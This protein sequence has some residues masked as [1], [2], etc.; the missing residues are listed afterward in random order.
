[1]PAELQKVIDT[2]LK[3]FPVANAF[4]DDILVVLKGIEIEHIALV[5]KILRKLNVSK[6]ALKLRKSEFAKNECE[7]LDFRI[8]KDGVTPLV[9]KNQV[10]EDLK[11]PKSRKQLKLLMGSLHSLHKFLPKIAEVSST[12]RPLLSLNNEFIWASACDNTFQQ[13]KWLVKIFVELKHYDIHRKHE[14]SA[15]LVMTVLGPC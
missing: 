4:I 7:W 13:L 1:M 12:F 5:E 10:V 9:Q 14:K 11:P 15:A 8:G 6:T 2:L 3:K